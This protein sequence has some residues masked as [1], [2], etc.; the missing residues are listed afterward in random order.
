MLLL[1]LLQH[2]EGLFNKKL[3]PLPFSLPSAP[4]KCEAAVFEA[5]AVGHR[6]ALPRKGEAARPGLAGGLGFRRRG[7]GRCED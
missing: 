5:R 7:G 2:K 4:A 1:L 3:Y 6:L